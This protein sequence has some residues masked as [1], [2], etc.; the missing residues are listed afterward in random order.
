MVKTKKIQESGQILTVTNDTLERIQKDPEPV[1]I[2]QHQAKQ[3]TK[4]KELSEKQK[5]HLD[6]IIEANRIK[7][8]AKRKQ[9]ED[10]FKK[11]LE[12]EEKLKQQNKIKDVVVLPKRVYPPRKKKVIQTIEESEEEQS[13]ESEESEEIVVVKKRKSVKAQKVD[14][15]HIE[16]KVEAVKKIDNLIASNPY[17]KYLSM[18][19]F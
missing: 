3:L 13:E 8:Q 1:T 4:K 18:I 10:E 2:S 17:N 6:K 16:K 19:K 9:K 11:K 12:E 5:E 15:E 14:L 7:W